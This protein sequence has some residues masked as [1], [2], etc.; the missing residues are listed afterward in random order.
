MSLILCISNICESQHCCLTS[1]GVWKYQ[2]K[3]SKIKN[4]NIIKKIVIN[5]HITNDYTMWTL[6]KS[7]IIDEYMKVGCRWLLD[8]I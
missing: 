1:L 2:T 4:K 5:S 8:V 6:K 7:A 3:S